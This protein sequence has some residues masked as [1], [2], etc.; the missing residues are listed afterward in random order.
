MLLDTLAL[1]DT[2]A[3]L[4]SLELQPALVIRLRLAALV[5]LD[6]LGFRLRLAALV[7]LLHPAPHQHL[8]SLGFRLRPVHLGIPAHLG[9]PVRLGILEPPSAL[10]YRLHPDSLADLG[11][12][13]NLAP[14]S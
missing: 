5:P 1:L 8:D 14:N 7:R 13:E 6:S 9:I 4:G 2:P 10:G 11:I 12:L 3:L